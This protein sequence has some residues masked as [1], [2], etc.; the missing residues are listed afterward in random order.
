MFTCTHLSREDAALHTLITSFL[1][2][3]LGE[4]G[5]KSQLLALAFAAKYPAGQVMLGVTLA[6]ALLQG[7]A[8]VVGCC[9]AEVIPMKAISIVAGLSF[10]LFG[11]WTLRGEQDGD[12]ATRE[13]RFGPLMTVA[14]T[15]FLAEM[16]DKTQLATVAL[17]ADFQSPVAVFLGATAGMVVADGIVVLVGDLFLRRIS[18]RLM[19]IASAGIFMVFGFVT[20]FQATGSSAASLAHLGGLAVATAAASCWVLRADRAAGSEPAPGGERSADECA[21]EG[22]A[23]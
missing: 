13:C 11:L 22:Q 12:E 5:D 18:P 16:G 14:L 4:M 17:A 8:V 20:L 21:R 7:L 15:F 9:L 23:E 6:T 2:V 3:A 19:K 10:L 1:M